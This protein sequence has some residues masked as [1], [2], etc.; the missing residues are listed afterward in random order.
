VVQRS[1]RKR[2]DRSRVRCHVERLENRELLSTLMEGLAANNLTGS[3]VAPLGN[4]FD[5]VSDGTVGDD[6][7]ISAPAAGANK[8]EVYVV[9]GGGHLD[10]QPPVVNGCI[11]RPTRVQNCNL[12]DT[13]LSDRVAVRIIGERAGDE[14]GYSVTGVGDVVG[15]S[16]PDILI[17]APFA[18][19]SGLE[20]SGRAYL[21][22]GEVIA[23]AISAAR[24]LG[25][26]AVATI[27]LA[28]PIVAAT[29]IRVFDGVS[30]GD[31]A[32]NSVTGLGT[33]YIMVGA[34][35][36]GTGLKQERGA[37]YVFAPLRGITGAGFLTP[38]STVSGPS[39]N[40]HLGGVP[41]EELTS[42]GF[43]GYGVSGI[44]NPALVPVQDDVAANEAKYSVLGSTTPDA[45]A[46]APD[47]CVDNDCLTL[48]AE[49]HGIAYLL[50]G[51]A[52]IT[53]GG[54]YDLSS[55]T[56]LKLLAAIPVQGA[57]DGDRFGA[58]VSSAGDLDDD[59]ISDFM[60]GAPDRDIASAAQNQPGLTNAGEIYIVFGR[61]VFSIPFP[62]GVCQSDPGRVGG[63][64]QNFRQCR[65]ATGL[66]VPLNAGFFSR[67]GNS[68]GVILQ[69]ESANERAGAALA[70]AG[71]FV[72][73]LG[74]S[75][76]LTPELVG[77]N[78]ILIGAPFHDLSTPS[79]FFQAAGRAY[80]LFGTSKLQLSSGEIVNLGLL[81]DTNRGLI[82]DGRESNGHYGISVNAAGNA[83]DPLGITGGD[84]LVGAS[85]IDV[86]LNGLVAPN[87]GEVE[88]FFGSTGGATG[89]ISQIGTLPFVQP[90]TYGPQIFIGGYWSFTNTMP[91]AGSVVLFPLVP[92]QPTDL[93]LNPPATA[94][95]LPAGSV[96]PFIAAFP[97][98][99]PLFLPGQSS[100]EHKR[101]KHRDRDDEDRHRAPVGVRLTKQARKALA[102]QYLDAV[103]G[104]GA[105]SR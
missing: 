76:L 65:D 62:D 53:L 10:E 85:N 81:D 38:I 82:I 25:G 68:V 33:G 2:P 5:D 19:N 43:R 70:E 92:S 61:E 74:R 6:F 87:V 59:G 91:P 15:D 34:P 41:A 102:A 96:G 3:S 94:P 71:N 37:V 99:A 56:D 26:S 4:I 84:I 18:L 14:F 36:N 100:N 60:I 83:H 95:M 29:T 63:A 31:Q 72:D 69:G 7:A 80:V 64:N 28:Q 1:K 66:V 67:T 89:V 57:G 78:E 11:A 20:S 47:A 75:A 27:D 12:I 79:Q 52:L 97:Y 93:I 45:I 55:D 86:T 17:G 73:P 22:G 40:A 51:A 90:G 77:V 101:K 46:G 58:T 8:G 49:R 50:S 30:A 105:A 44:R 13:Y 39:F 42:T 23:A 35:K 21:I 54:T 88:I 24:A 98:S 9:F 16:R 103:A 48:D 32:G 104:L